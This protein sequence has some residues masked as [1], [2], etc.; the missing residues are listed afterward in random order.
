MAVILDTEYID[1]YTARVLA[2]K[3]HLLQNLYI[4]KPSHAGDEYLCHECRK[5]GG[6]FLDKL[7]AKCYDYII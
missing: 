2:E 6:I 7:G 1:F 3:G 5:E 4:A